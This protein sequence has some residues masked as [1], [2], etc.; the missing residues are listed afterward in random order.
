VQAAL[1]VRERPPTTRTVAAAK[2]TTA[3]MVRRHVALRMFRMFYTLST[4]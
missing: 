1:A 3:T 4:Y 2:I